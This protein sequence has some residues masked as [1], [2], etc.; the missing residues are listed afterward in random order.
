MVFLAIFVAIISCHLETVS[1][2]E[3]GLCIV[4]LFSDEMRPLNYKQFNGK[5]NQDGVGVEGVVGVVVVVVVGEGCCCVCV[6]GGGGGGGGGAVGGGVW[7]CVCVLG[8]G[9]GRGWSD[10]QAREG[11]SSMAYAVPW[12]LKLLVWLI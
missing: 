2:N 1:S 4:K 6:C 10:I 9:G 12:C 5:G 11:Q 8:R 7:M 3:K